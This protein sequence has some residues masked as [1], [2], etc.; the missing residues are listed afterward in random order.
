VHGFFQ[1]SIA[2]AR[3]AVESGLNQHIKRKLGAIPET[4]LARKIDTAARLN[5]VSPAGAKLAHG[6]RK[7]ARD[8]L[9]RK[10]AKDNLAFDTIM[11]AR[12]FLKELF[13]D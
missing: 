5:L 7:T 11:Q 9:H 6:V 3:A 2:L 8:V 4:E 10:P 13:G 1:A 12:G